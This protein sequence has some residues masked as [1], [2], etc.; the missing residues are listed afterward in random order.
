MRNSFA[1][2]FANRYE[3]HGYSLMALT[4][5][6]HTSVAGLL[7]VTLYVLTAVLLLLALR[8]KRLPRLV[9]LLMT[10][11]PAVLLHGLLTWQQMNK[12]DGFYLGFFTAGSLVALV[13]TVLVLL[14]A[15]RLPVQNL[16]I[17][18][19]PISMAA[20]IG[21]LAGQT[22]F[23]PRTT[24]PA[25]LLAHILISLTA[26]CVLFMAACQ[27][28]LLTYQEHLLRRRRAMVN[29]RLLPPLETME[30]FLFTL[31]WVGVVTL[32]LAIGTGFA[33]LDDLF[34]QHVVHHTVLAIASWVLYAGILAGHQLFGWRS[35]TVTYG[36][37]IAFALLLLGYFGSKFVLEILLDR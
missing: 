34:A 12:P 10:A 5:P 37:L 22:G 4:F 17:L 15:I 30:S 36:T 11:V 9:L 19:L 31:L 13:M 1:S 18:V 24:V 16:L 35:Y 23:E 32:S 20:L 8:R 25:P 7:A 14:S 3:P 28:L 21:S 29:L 33:F 2:T 6:G 27:A 26:Y